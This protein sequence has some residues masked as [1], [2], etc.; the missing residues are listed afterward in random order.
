MLEHGGDG[1][2]RASRAND[3][4]IR[5]VQ[6]GR[7]VVHRDHGERLADV[8]RIEDLVRDLVLVPPDLAAKLEVVPLRAHDQIAGHVEEVE[9]QLAPP[10]V[11]ERDPLLHRFARPQHPDFTQLAGT[12]TVRRAH[13]ARLVA[14]RRARVA[15]SVRVDDRDLRAHLAQVE[16]RPAA[17]CARADDDDVRR[18]SRSHER[19][20]RCRRDLRLSAPQIR[21]ADEER[22]RAR[23]GDLQKVAPSDGTVVEVR[24]FAAPRTGARLHSG[25]SAARRSSR[26][27]WGR[28][29]ESSGRSAFPR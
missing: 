17:P 28:P 6:H 21:P 29:R 10:L 12:I 20:A 27:K 23:A 2:A 4:G 7:D 22:A 1:L 13:A 14:R 5:L 18:L 26:P 15:R 11:V 24:I 8:V 25:S 19:H 16:R 3:A 9:P